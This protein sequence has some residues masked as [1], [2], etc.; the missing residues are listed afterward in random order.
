MTAE[1]EQTGVTDERTA[2]HAHAIHLQRVRKANA[3]VREAQTALRNTVE[4]A[5][6]AGRTW[7]DIAAAFNS[8]GHSA[9]PDILGISDIPSISDIVQTVLGTS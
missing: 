3:A 6:K 7:E 5:R 2:Q 4:D 8:T 9:T 1:P